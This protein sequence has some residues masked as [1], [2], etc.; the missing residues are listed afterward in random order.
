MCLTG[1]I[2]YFK[3]AVLSSSITGE[4]DSERG[5]SRDK[6]V[7]VVVTG[8]SSD[9]LGR[10]AVTIVDIE[11]ISRAQVDV[12]KCQSNFLCSPWRPDEPLAVQHVQVIVRVTGRS[13]NS[14]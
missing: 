6:L 8:V 2:T 9:D 10:D 1:V 12:I 3:A 4:P 11:I 13:N 5:T 7:S 14:S